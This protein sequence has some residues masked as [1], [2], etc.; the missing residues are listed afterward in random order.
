MSSS[1][2]RKGLEL[3]KDDLQLSDS[4]PNKQKSRPLSKEQILGTCKQGQK[5]KLKRMKRKQMQAAANNKVIKS[6]FEEHKKRALPDYTKDN[7]YFIKM[8]EQNKIKS[9]KVDKILE[10][11]SR[12]QIRDTEGQTSAETKPESTVFDES[13]FSK[14]EK[15]FN[16]T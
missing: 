8:L 14:F 5:N 6:A 16:F 1:L 13:D 7:L 2:I 11:H 15:E 4:K 3:F 9:S 12:K 10:Q